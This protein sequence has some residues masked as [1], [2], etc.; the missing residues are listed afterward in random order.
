MLKAFLILLILPIT[1]WINKSSAATYTAIQSGLFSASSSWDN[2]VPPLVLSSTDTI[3]I[4]AGITIKIDNNI[5]VNTVGSSIVIDG[6]LIDSVTYNFPSI[7]SDTLYIGQGH[8]GGSGL[9]AI[10]NFVA[11]QNLSLDFAGQMNIAFFYCHG[12]KQNLATTKVT[13]KSNL[14][15]LENDYLIS[16]GVLALDSFATVNI[17]DGNLKPS[18]N[19][20]TIDFNNT[21]TISYNNIQARLT[22]EELNFGTAAA[23]IYISTATEVR[24]SKDLHIY[25]TLTFR[26][27]SLTLAGHDLVFENTADFYDLS[28]FSNHGRIY[29]DTNSNV[30]VYCDHNLSDALNINGVLNDFELNM[31][32][33]KSVVKIDADLSVSGVLYLKQG[34]LDVGFSRIYATTLGSGTYGGSEHSYL[35]MEDTLTVTDYLLIGQLWRWIPS[36][37][38]LHFPVGTKDHYT[39]VNVTNHSSTADHAKVSAI[40]GVR[41]NG[42]Y[43]YFLSGNQP[44]TSVSWAVQTDINP[45]DA[46]VELTWPGTCEV[47]G[48]NRNNAYISFY[49]EY[50][51]PWDSITPGPAYSLPGGYYG[52]K[53]T[54]KYVTVFGNR[55]RHVYMAIFDDKTSLFSEDIFASKAM[56]IYPN[57]V[58]DQMTITGIDTKMPVIVTNIS[59]QYFPL[60]VTLKGNDILMNTTNLPY[61]V[62]FV[63]IGGKTAK[64]VKQY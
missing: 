28:G 18:G 6:I 21:H 16:N 25:R 5:T 54:F 63:R 10:R 9:I 2:G 35:I 36:G 43:G 62:Y 55:N 11:L 31:G 17:Y 30:R 37:A 42:V 13:I 59:G 46:E 3:T 22:G 38:T 23:D 4:P 19:Q 61:G 60:P 40:D 52:L 44:T 50:P 29:A 8:I 58:M 51:T 14:Y 20:Y 27:G 15:L 1:C 57:P 7:Y 49:K 12:I 56:S 64:F 48:L 47:N 32:A 41:Y 24:L 45:D 34:L 33:P 39:P 53:R 26:E